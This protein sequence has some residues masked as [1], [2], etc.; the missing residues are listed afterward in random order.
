MNLL[1]IRNHCCTYFVLEKMSSPPQPDRPTDEQILQYV[2]TIKEKEVEVHPLV[3]PDEPLVNL[4]PEYEA[5]SPSFCTKIDHL[6]ESYDKFRRCRGDGN[7]FYR[8]YGFRLFEYLLTQPQATLEIISDVYRTEHKALMLTAGFEEFAF[9]DFYDEFV[10]LLS[11]LKNIP[12]YMRR[13]EISAEGANTDTDRLLAI[14]QNDIIS[15][16]IVVHLRFI[17]SAFL[18]ANAEMYSPFLD[19]GMTMEIF[20]NQFVEAM[21][22]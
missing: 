7:C 2:A 1:H 6:C 10:D 4:K 22:R 15:N 9:I 16:S 17:T 19:D 11:S 8:A 20:C 14:F 13:H 21:D 12:D 18:K 5:G 3:S